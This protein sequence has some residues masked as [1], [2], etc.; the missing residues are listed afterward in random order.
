[1]DP[2]IPCLHILSLDFSKFF[3]ASLDS[4]SPTFP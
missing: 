2:K 3:S 4:T 1:M